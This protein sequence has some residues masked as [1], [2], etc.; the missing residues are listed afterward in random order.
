MTACDVA[1]GTGAWQSN[2]SDWQGLWEGPQLG[3][4]NPLLSR[5]SVRARGGARVSQVREALVRRGP[6]GAGGSSQLGLRETVA[7]RRSWRMRIGHPKLG[8]HGR[9]YRKAFVTARLALA[10]GPTPRAQLPGV[11]G[12]G[13]RALITLSCFGPDGRRWRQ[14]A[15]PAGAPFVCGGW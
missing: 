14:G 2:V 13:I 5:N 11:I 4:L 15:E 9:H 6:R 7:P 8:P 3:L 12:S 1:S 10:A